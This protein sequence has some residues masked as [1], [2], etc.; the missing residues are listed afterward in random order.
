MIRA[1]ILKEESIPVRGGDNSHL[2]NVANITYAWTRMR[3]NMASQ[4]LNG[5]KEGGLRAPPALRL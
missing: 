5:K 1:G 3:K 2:P 4:A